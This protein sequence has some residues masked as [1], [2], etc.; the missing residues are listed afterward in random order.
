MRTAYT[1]CFRAAIAI[2]CCTDSPAAGSAGVAIVDVTVVDVARGRDLE[3]RT[4]LV[5]GERITATPRA[6]D[7]RI[8]AEAVRVDGRGRWLM[9][10]LVDMHVHL[11]NTY[12]HRP[13][14]EWALPLFVANGVTGVR[15]MAADAA[16]IAVL[17][18]WRREVD[19]G[20]RVAPRVL[21]AGIA[22]RVRE[23]ADAQGAVDAIADAGAGFVKVFSEVGATQWQAILAAAHDRSLPVAG[24]VPAS[25]ALLEAAD[26]GQRTDEHLM[27]AYEACS[28]I[29][30]ALLHERAGLA[31][32]AL[33]AMRDAQEARALAAFDLAACQRVA[34]RLAASGQWQVPTLVLAWTET[35]RGNAADADPRWPLLR[36]DERE[37]WTR[38]LADIGA[39]PDPLARR[40]WEVSRAIVSAYRRANVPMMAGTD[41][42]MPEVYPGYSLHDE[43]ERLVEAGLTPRE[44]LQAATFAPAR[45]LG[46]EATSGTVAPGKYADL[47]LLT[48]DP[49]R[50]VRNARR[51][52]AVL[53]S[54]RLLR[55]ADLD[56]LLQPAM[57]MRRM[58]R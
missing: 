8:P 5:D 52:D 25:I 19:A 21:A 15:E 18:Q 37:R 16:S 22:A 57:A 36:A 39:H 42:P 43:L 33:T 2:A 10:G 32:E 9:P 38:I 45:F 29:E 54:G 27:Q 6:D 24:H 41:A 7:A 11:F 51:I 20:A 35:R 53:L 47:V 48:A 12:S 3:H 55:R 23:P 31:G 50:D 56:A 4:V 17:R 1:S 26:H 44:A 49:T 34:R 14:N 46:I 58:P 28:S 13:P 40:R 30:D